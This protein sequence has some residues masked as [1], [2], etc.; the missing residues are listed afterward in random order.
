MELIKLGNGTT[1]GDTVGPGE[2]G[3]R[4]SVF[5]FSSAFKTHVNLWEGK[6]LVIPNQELMSGE[7][8]G[9][10]WGGWQVKAVSV[11]SVLRCE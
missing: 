3:S 10:W 1:K 8:L 7:G 5:L 6:N 11:V 9:W 4:D 2:V